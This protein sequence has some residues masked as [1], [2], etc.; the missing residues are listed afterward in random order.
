VLQLKIAPFLIDEKQETIDG[1]E[2]KKDLKFLTEYCETPAN[3]KDIDRTRKEPPLLPQSLTFQLWTEYF[4]WPLKYKMKDNK[5]TE[6]YKG[7]KDEYISA[8]KTERLNPDC[9]YL[10]TRITIYPL[11]KTLIQL[12][13]CP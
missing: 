3:P 8:T 5:T 4:D 11:I 2:L 7:K 9:W 12:R 6:Y 1:S 13:D 10:F